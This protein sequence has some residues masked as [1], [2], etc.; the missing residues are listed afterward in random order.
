MMNVFTPAYPSIVTRYL[1]RYGSDKW[2]VR[3]GRQKFYDN[4]IVVPAIAEYDNINNLLNSLKKNDRN[5]LLKTMI[6]F[7]INN[8][9]NAS[10]EIKTN[11]SQTIA[12][13]EKLIYGDGLIIGYV[14]A[15][16]E[17][18]SMPDK[19]AGVGLA[20][21]IG[22]DLALTLFDYNSF[23]KKLL[24]C[25]DADC[26]VKNNYLS[27]IVDVFNK[28]RIEA[29]VIE[30]EHRLPEDEL[31]K[32]A[33]I[34][35]EIFLRYYVLGLS[36]AKSPYAIHSVG[37]TMVCDYES[38]IKIGGM[39]KRKAAED[40]YFLEKLAKVVNIHKIS[41]TKVYPSSRTSWRVPFGTG[42]RMN[43]FRAGTHEEFSLFDFR[44]FELLKE[45]NAYYYSDEI[46]TVTEYLSFAGK[47]NPALKNFLEL[48]SFQ[49]QWEKILSNAKSIEQIRKQ[50]KIWFD[51][52]RTMKL[53][54]YLRDNG[55]PNINMFDAL[56]DLYVKLKIDTNISRNE[57][58]PSIQIQQNYLQ[59]LK[60]AGS[61]SLNQN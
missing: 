28:D 25:L 8:G 49:N 30:Y 6:L 34:C 42:Q 21:K 33:I 40:F 47:L 32:S 58:I 26:E 41:Q 31:S 61:V 22:M 37:S 23:N 2:S 35:Y 50:K 51:G 3:Q 44:I 27:V 60:E 10:E 15:S 16:T 59:T 4:I 43:R 19:D 56:D 36:Y 5:Y 39:N 1:Q 45:W 55:F 17:G 20:R 7:V 54:H 29:A 12:L 14:D 24:I 53:I 48:N 11:N 52:F 18:F 9:E 46:I 38:Y 13:L 57:S